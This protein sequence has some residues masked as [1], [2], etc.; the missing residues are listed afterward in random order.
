M[1]SANDYSLQV[2]AAQKL[3]LAKTPLLVR[4]LMGNIHVRKISKFNDETIMK[5]VESFYHHYE[6]PFG[7]LN[8][9][10]L[11]AL[12]IQKR[13]EVL[14]EK[15][16]DDPLLR[17]LR[18]F[19]EDRQGKMICVLLLVRAYLLKHP[20]LN[21]SALRGSYIYPQPS[22]KFSSPFL[23]RNRE[24]NSFNIPEMVP[25]ESK[26]G[27]TYEELIRRA[28]APGVLRLEELGTLQM[29]GENIMLWLEERYLL[30]PQKNAKLAQEI[31]KVTR[32]LPFYSSGVMIRLGGRIQGN[33]L[34]STTYYILVKFPEHIPCEFAPSHP[35]EFTWMI[36]L[37]YIYG[38]EDCRGISL[39]GPLNYGYRFVSPRWEE[40]ENV[41]E[42]LPSFTYYQDIKNLKV[43]MENRVRHLEICSLMDSLRRA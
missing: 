34:L 14:W 5:A 36:L 6:D 2:Q 38:V 19:Y 26:I 3:P 23:V 35:N 8:I 22:C 10:K 41:K 21:A 27:L 20:S 42:H 12:W 18:C 39:T 28:S 9:H 40:V 37:S 15:Y 25:T 4:I 43:T 16:G 7:E 13:V 24:I 31:L 30:V 1:L 29:M 17:K 32:L 33:V 11:F